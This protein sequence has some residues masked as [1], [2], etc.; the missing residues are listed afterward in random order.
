MQFQLRG[1]KISYL[2]EQ[3]GGFECKGEEESER[4]GGKQGSNGD[5][6]G[7]SA[8]L[9]RIV[10][11]IS[12]IYNYDR[13]KCAWTF[14]PVA[15]VTVCAVRE[16]RKRRSGDVDEEANLV[17][18]LSISPFVL[19]ILPFKIAPHSFPIFQFTSYII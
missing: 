15:E 17:T 5:K 19:D 12:V 16:R 4:V 13:L 2:W 18:I 7:G 11:R 8:S 3:T 1:A 9:V 14:Y 6:C 10:R